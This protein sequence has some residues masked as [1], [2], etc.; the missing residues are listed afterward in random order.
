M[1]TPTSRSDND[2]NQRHDDRID[3]TITY[4][5]Q[6][7][8]PVL[9]TV[10]PPPRTKVALLRAEHPP[11]HFYRYL[12]RIIGEPYHWV[13]RR[14]LD[15]KALAEIIHNPDVYLYILYVD[16]VPAGMAEIDERKKELADLKFFGLVPDFTGKSLG[17]Y[18][19]FNVIDLAWSRGPQKLRL[20][21]C[22]LDHPAA[23]PLYQKAGFS[24][25]DR[26]KGVIDLSNVPPH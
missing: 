20:E 6:V 22:S 11:I 9:P 24:V 26:R 14:R 19:L 21:T 1:M 13:S 18:F 10:A 25:Y 23:L 17:R 4:L 15:D 8:R 3:V 7:E 5:E 12:Y 2:D 16:G